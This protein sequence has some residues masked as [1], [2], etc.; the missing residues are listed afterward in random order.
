MTT[1]HY[2]CLIFQ[3]FFACQII[4]YRTYHLYNALWR[5]R[6]V[7]LA[8]KTPRIRFR[9]FDSRFDSSITLVECWRDC[10]LFT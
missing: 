2:L 4:S 5:F 7:N 10:R 1:A 8:T 3:M 6:G 9:I